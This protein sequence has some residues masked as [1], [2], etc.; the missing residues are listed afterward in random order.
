M[1]TSPQFWESLCRRRPG[2]MGTII[3]ASPERTLTVRSDKGAPPMIPSHLVDEASTVRSDKTILSLKSP[4]HTNM[5]V[6][7]ARYGLFIFG[8][9]YPFSHFNTWRPVID[10]FKAKRAL[11]TTFP[12][13]GCF[14]Y[15][16][17]LI[18]SLYLRALTEQPAS[19]CLVPLNA[20]TYASDCFILQQCMW[21][22]V[23]PV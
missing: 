12:V 11:G 6:S 16:P 8:N 5:P 9:A 19:I 7:R 2:A 14:A 23:F 22:D 3:A 1:S 21:M 15:S 20:A 10:L 18:W 4:N 13:A 17:V